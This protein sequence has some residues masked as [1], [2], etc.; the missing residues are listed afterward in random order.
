[1]QF[2]SNL[3]MTKYFKVNVNHLNLSADVKRIHPSHEGCPGRGAKRL[4]VAL[5][6]DHSL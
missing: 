4:D 3:S 5:V 2:Q 6:Q 1:M